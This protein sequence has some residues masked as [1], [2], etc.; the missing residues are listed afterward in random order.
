MLVVHGPQ[1]QCRAASA[2]QRLAS[3][4]CLL[5]WPASGCYLQ[6][7]LA[8]VGP[9]PSQLDSAFCVWS[10]PA[11]VCVDAASRAAAGESVLRLSQML[12]RGFANV[13]LQCFEPELAV[14]GCP[15]LNAIEAKNMSS[16]ATSLKAP[17]R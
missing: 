4:C 9:L 8:S 1:L 13:H 17:Q 14:H 16:A 15:A 5:S 2:G 10:W 12:A 3:A 6:A 7:R 11:S